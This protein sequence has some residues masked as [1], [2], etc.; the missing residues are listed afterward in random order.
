MAAGDPVVDPT[1]TDRS[2]KGKS[3]TAS[4]EADLKAILDAKAAM[5]GKP[6][7]VV[8]EASKPMIFSEF[9]NRVDGILVGFGIQHQAMFDMI[10]GA[11]EPS[12]LLPVQ[13]PAN[14]STVEKQ[15]EDV[16]HDMEPH[17]DSEGHKYDFGY[18]LNWKGVI[19]DSRTGRYRKAK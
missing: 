8:V 18:G 7:I 17:V 5:N 10:S 12:G 19:N 11:A 6:V 2:Y 15:F 4:N 3:V 13:M 14:M 9:E 16:P 1:I